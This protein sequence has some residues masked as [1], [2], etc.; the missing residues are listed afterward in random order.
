[1]ERGT[2]EKGFPFDRFSAS[3]GDERPSQEFPAEILYRIVSG[4]WQSERKPAVTRWEPGCGPGSQP[5]LC[6]G[7]SGATT[8]P[9]HPLCRAGWGPLLPVFCRYRWG[10]P[11]V[12]RLS[13]ASQQQLCEPLGFTC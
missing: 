13:T 1:M 9:Q 6:G 12:R 3:I 11:W 2:A 10:N 4:F 7:G 8:G 5:V